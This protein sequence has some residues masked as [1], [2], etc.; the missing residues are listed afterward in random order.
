MRPDQLLL[1]FMHAMKIV[2]TLDIG[3]QPV[4]LSIAIL[5]RQIEQAHSAAA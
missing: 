1:G 3:K 2:Q 5:S 4:H